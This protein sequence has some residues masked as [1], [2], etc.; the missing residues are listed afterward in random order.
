MKVCSPSEQTICKSFCPSG[1]CRSASHSK[2]EKNTFYARLTLESN[3]EMYRE[4][5]IDHLAL[6]FPK[7]AAI[8]LHPKVCCKDAAGILLCREGS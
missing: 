5:S 7:L 2:Y 4:I 3:T 6:T 1:V 8:Y